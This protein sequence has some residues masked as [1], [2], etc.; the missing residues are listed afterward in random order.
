MCRGGGYEVVDGKEGV[1]RKMVAGCWD[2]G[3][4]EERYSDVT[5]GLRL[6]QHCGVVVS[7]G[8]LVSWVGIPRVE[9][10]ADI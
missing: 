9:E 10:M 4:I 6:L 8:S 7:T 2:W 3:R 1:G 5:K